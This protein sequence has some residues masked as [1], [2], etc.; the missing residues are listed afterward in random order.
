MDTCCEAGEI[1]NLKTTKEL[2]LAVYGCYLC[3]QMQFTKK[4]VKNVVLWIMC[5]M[6]FDSTLIE[7][8]T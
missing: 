6:A 3:V 7:N 5:F 4:K 8:S 1:T 2:T